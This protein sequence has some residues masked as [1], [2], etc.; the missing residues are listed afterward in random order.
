MLEGVHLTNVPLYIS[1]KFYAICAGWYVTTRQT[2]WLLTTNKCHLQL[3]QISEVTIFTIDKKKCLQ[4]KFPLFKFLPFN[5]HHKSENF[6]SYKYL[7]ESFFYFFT[8][9]YLFT[10][11]PRSCYITALGYICFCLH[12]LHYTYYSTLFF[13]W[14]HIRRPA[15]K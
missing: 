12:I 11:L 9:I 2:F 7:Q 13:F 1:R 3:F 10:S 15:D 14:L 4:S 8:G 5:W 6:M